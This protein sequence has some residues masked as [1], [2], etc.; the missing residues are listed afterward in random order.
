MKI[1]LFWLFIMLL[2]LFIIDRI[3]HHIINILNEFRK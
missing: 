1:L 2:I 3:F